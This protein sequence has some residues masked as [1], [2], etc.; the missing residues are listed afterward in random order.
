LKNTAAPPILQRAAGGAPFKLSK[1]TSMLNYVV[2]ACFTDKGLQ[3]I[4]ETTKRAEAAKE[5]ASR[6]GVKM[7]EIYWTQGEYDI[8]TLCEASDEASISAFGLA[9]ASGGNVRFQTLRAFTSKEMDGI[10][11]K[12]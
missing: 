11:G 12:L 2:L 5:M 1:E 4:K 3:N 7:R 10:L 9:L 6:F 8:V